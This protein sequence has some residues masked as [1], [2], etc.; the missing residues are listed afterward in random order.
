LFR[1]QGCF[2]GCIEFSRPARAPSRRV[3]RYHLEGNRRIGLPRQRACLDLFGNPNDLA[4][5]ADQLAQRCV[6]QKVRFLGLPTQQSG[7]RRERHVL[8]Q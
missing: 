6:G 2:Y 1:S 7:R 4:V 5:V 8:A 3:M